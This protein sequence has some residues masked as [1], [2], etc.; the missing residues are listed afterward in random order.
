MNLQWNY[1]PSFPAHSFIVF[2]LQDFRH[3]DFVLL[4]QLHVAWRCLGNLFVTSLYQLT[5]GW[6]ANS[7]RDSAQTGAS[8]VLIRLSP[9]TK[10]VFE[11]WHQ[12]TPVG[13]F[14]LDHYTGVSLV[15][16]Y[17]PAGYRVTKGQGGKWGRG[18]LLWNLNSGRDV[19]LFK[20]TGP[21]GLKSC[22]SQFIPH[23]EAEMLLSKR[24]YC[25][26]RCTILQ[27]LTRFTSLRCFSRKT[28]RNMTDVIMLQNNYLAKL[29]HPM[30]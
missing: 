29:S 7:T 26:T 1:G 12:K 8:D 16:V 3:C 15:L 14:D 10:L 21:A 23:R 17:F 11:F 5:R 4:L 6:M 18:F 20:I 2:M 25:N 9:L 27:Q 13:L 30:S 22:H 24:T 28:W 19:C